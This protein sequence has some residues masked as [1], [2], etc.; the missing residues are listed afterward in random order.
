MYLLQLLTWAMLVL[1]CWQITQAEEKPAP[2]K[3]PFNATQALASQQSWARYSNLASHEITN[4]INMKLVVIPPGTFMMGR[5]TIE[6]TISSH[7]TQHEVTLTRAF[8]MST[9]EI[10]QAQF[11]SL[12]GRNPSSF[13]ASKVGQNTDNFPVEKVTWYDCVE[14]SNKLSEKESLSPFYR[15]TNIERGRDGQLTNA[16][17]TIPDRDGKGYRLPTE[18]EWE[19]ACRAGTTSPFHFGKV[20]TG[21]DSNINGNYPYGT[22][23]KGPY[24]ERTISVG[25]YAPNAF[26]LFDM[27]G[28]VWEWCED[29]YVS[30]YYQR[31]PKSDPVATNEQSG[32]VLR[33]GSWFG[34]AWN[35]QSA[36]RYRGAPDIRSDDR[37]FRVSRTF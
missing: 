4:S 14:Y 32:R 31:S 33:G 37:G 35:T 20:S 12:M 2:L 9:H 36:N 10:T 3:A 34:N 16:D 19:Y 24:L 22:K 23:T 11:K 7:E 18:A 8:L 27:H 30:E 17:V 28:N 1:T 29:W 26:G 25:S 6:T 13:N 5:P 21:K 15:I